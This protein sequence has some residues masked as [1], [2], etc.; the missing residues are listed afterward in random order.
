MREG[1]GI[2]ELARQA[3]VRVANIRYYE[4][5]GMMPKAGRGRGGQRL[6]GESD[7]KQLR[8]VKNCRELG[9]PLKQVRALVHLSETERR[10]CN[11]ARDLAA[12][13]LAIVRRRLTELRAL[14]AEL[15]KQVLDCD[16][17]CFNGPAPECSIFESLSGGAAGRQAGCCDV[18]ALFF[19]AQ[20][21]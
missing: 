5:I 11:E 14:E 13:Q 8:F 1:Y 21:S 15:D 3:G 4:Q 16:S 12:E 17:G 7:L 6:Y 2:G 19:P 20:G 10:T 18:P 9:Y